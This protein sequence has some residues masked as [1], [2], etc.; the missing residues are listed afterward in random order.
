MHFTPVDTVLSVGLD[1]YSDGF[2]IFAKL[3]ANPAVRDILGFRYSRRVEL[4]AYGS[5]VWRHMSA[6]D[7][8]IAKQVMLLYKQG[9]YPMRITRL[10]FV[11]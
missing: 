2:H 1:Q 9:S 10:F 4:L 8:A 11:N 6:L 5:T 7:R 3:P